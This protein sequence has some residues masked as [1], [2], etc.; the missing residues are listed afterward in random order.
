MTRES[1]TVEVLGWFTS[2]SRSRRGSMAELP[3]GTVTFLFTDLE[4]ST[5]LWQDAP[6]SMRGASARHDAIVREAIESHDGYVVKTTGDGFH[7]AFA[8]ARDAIDAAVDAQ[9]ALSAEAWEPT[10]PLRVRMGIHSGLA[11]VRDGDYYGTSVNKAARL[12]SVAHGGQIVVSL[13]TEELVQDGEVDLVDLGEHS[14]RDLARP[15]RVF[16]VAHDGLARDFPRLSSLEAFG[17][18][19]PLQVSSFVGRDDDVAR[20]VEMLGDAALVT[21]TG[22][23]GVGK[24]RLAVQAAAEAVPQFPDGAWFCELAAVD[25]GDAMAQ[26]VAA[27]LGCVQRA[28]LSLAQSI[29]EYLKV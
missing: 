7:A 12:T 3:S 26:V 15:E 16:Q 8:S 4:G 14:L 10:A 24:T 13:A 29:V 20:I 5:R 21:L 6:D 2:P 19:L 11:E 17:G 28:G 23:G 22:T 25:D 18:N 1:T 27:S 9:I